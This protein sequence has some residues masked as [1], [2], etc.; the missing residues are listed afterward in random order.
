MKREDAAK[1]VQN[2]SWYVSELVGFS[3]D[4]RGTALT[5]MQEWIKWQETAEDGDDGMSNGAKAPQLLAA[6]AAA[7]AQND[8]KNQYILVPDD[9]TL[10]NLPCPI[11]HEPFEKSYDDAISDWVWKDAVKVG[12]RVYHASEYADMK[13]DGGNTPLRTATPDSVLGKRKA[14]VSA[15]NI[16]Q[17]QQRRDDTKMWRIGR[18][19]KCNA[20]E[21]LQGD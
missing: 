5:A 13:K 15:P 10:A 20:V 9:H 17:R 16:L 8:P 7:A 14:G 21:N 19:C 2:R 4:G 12:P 11:C 3:L 1:R 18:R 6:D